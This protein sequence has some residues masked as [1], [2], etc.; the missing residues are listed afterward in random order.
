MSNIG[1]VH[2][3]LREVDVKGC[4]A[5]NQLTYVQRQLSELREVLE[6]TLGESAN[7]AA[8]NAI[9]LYARFDEQLTE[10]RETFHAARHHMQDYDVQL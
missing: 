6:Q 7:P 8:Q 1:E 5:G 9:A 10:A 3:A 2:A 4:E